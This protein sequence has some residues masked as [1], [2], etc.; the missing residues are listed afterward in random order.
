M[1]KIV[2]GM[3]DVGN[4]TC[5]KSSGAGPNTVEGEVPERGDADQEWRP[6]GADTPGRARNG[7]GYH[8]SR[9]QGNTRRQRHAREAWHGMFLGML[10]APC[11]SANAAKKKPEVVG[12]GILLWIH[13]IPE[14]GAV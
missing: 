2:A 6:V 7:G 9:K 12:I 13:G 1:K 3:K 10:I 4:G 8:C 5:G 11:W 14:A